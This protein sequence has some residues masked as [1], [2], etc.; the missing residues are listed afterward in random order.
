MSTSPTVYVLNGKY[1][2]YDDSIPKYNKKT[3]IEK[4]NTFSNVTTETETETG[5]IYK[6]ISN[7]VMVDGDDN[8][9]SYD[10]INAWEMSKKFIQI[11]DTILQNKDATKN[12]PYF[13]SKDEWDA[14][15]VAP[16]PAPAPALAP[17]AP[18]A[19]ALAPALAPAPSW[20]SSLLGKKKGG[21]KSNKKRD[22]SK[23]NKKKKKSTQRK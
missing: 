15:S 6:T 19:P 21:R 9:Y 14:A 23:K 16:A 5:T 3:I 11:I 8:R 2:T 22:G 4:I 12:A 10:T 17:A 1:F 13:I 20:W 7:P 18:A